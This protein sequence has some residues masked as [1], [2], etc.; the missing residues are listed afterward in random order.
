VSSRAKCLGSTVLQSVQ[1]QRF[2]STLAYFVQISYPGRSK[3]ATSC[4]SVSR[5]KHPYVIP[6]L[7]PATRYQTLCTHN[8]H[9]GCFRIVLSRLTLALTSDTF[10]FLH[11]EHTRSSYFF[12][13]ATKCI[14]CT[15]AC[16]YTPCNTVGAHKL[17]R[18]H[19]LRF[20]RENRLNP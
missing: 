16:A 12:V 14:F 18:H 2:F 8:T 5:A 19:L 3:T 9:R 7:A 1:A 10:I 13:C 15:F 20:A 11:D 4:I 17:L 6:P